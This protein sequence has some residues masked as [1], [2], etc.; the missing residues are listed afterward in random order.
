MDVTN[1][2]A[3]QC[4]VTSWDDQASLFEEAIKFSPSGTIDI[5][6]ANAGLG[7][8]GDPLVQPGD[9]SGPAT[10]PDLRIL[11]VNLRGILYTTRLALHYL[12][13]FQNQGVSDRSLILMGSMSAYVDWE[14]SLQYPVSKGAV[15]TLMKC[16]RRMTWK[17]GIRVNSVA[18]GYIETVM[19]PQH[20]KS[21]M[22]EAGV[23]F[24]ET[25]D[26]V[27]AVMR[28]ATDPSLSNS[29]HYERS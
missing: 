16:L 10:K 2:Q 14:R 28:I 22:I 3:L 23:E 12:A 13:R 15:R 4:D 25:E 5:V 24:A 9:L 8:L 6:I 27:K 17:D 7:A 21:K 11:E 19:I 29:N 1:V 20:I 26:A 18:P